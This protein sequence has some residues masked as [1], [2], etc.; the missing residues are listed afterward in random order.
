[1]SEIQKS[2]ARCGMS[3]DDN[4]CQSCSVLYRQLEFLKEEIKSK[5]AQMKILKDK[6]QNRKPKVAKP[7]K[8]EFLNFL[9]NN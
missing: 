6:I 4:Y 8:E 2:C 3:T 7:K 1:M 9:D 5:L